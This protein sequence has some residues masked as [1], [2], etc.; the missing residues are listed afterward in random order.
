MNIIRNKESM[1]IL[2]YIFNFDLVNT[3]KTKSS[4]IRSAAA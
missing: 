3:E 2:E 1:Q 4:P